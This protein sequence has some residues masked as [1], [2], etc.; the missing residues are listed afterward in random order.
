MWKKQNKVDIVILFDLPKN[1][2]R[3]NKESLKS[4]SGENP[5]ELKIAYLYSIYIK[6]KTNRIYF[7]EP[8]RSN[9]ISMFQQLNNLY[10]FL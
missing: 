5:S 8:L 6:E 10:N 2:T 9:R 7:A 1:T 3:I 4:Q